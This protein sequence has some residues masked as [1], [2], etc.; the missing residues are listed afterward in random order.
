MLG[1]FYLALSSLHFGEWELVTLLV[2][3]LFV[4]NLVISHV[5]AFLIGFFFKL[6]PAMTMILF[7]FFLSDLF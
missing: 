7:N 1:L 5:F 3:C 4:L 2:A 6:W